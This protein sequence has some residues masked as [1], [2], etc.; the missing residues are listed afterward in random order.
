M[1][2]G[3]DVS[4]EELFLLPIARSCF[5]RV[6]KIDGGCSELGGNCGWEKCCTEGKSLVRGQAL[7]FRVR[8]LN[9]Q[10]SEFAI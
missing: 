9:M 6:F 1:I 5:S 2:A 10:V 7:C 3:P 8:N 4:A